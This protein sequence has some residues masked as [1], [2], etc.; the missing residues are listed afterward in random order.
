[1]NDF[2]MGGN[3]GMRQ[4]ASPTP[5]PGLMPAEL[6]NGSQSEQNGFG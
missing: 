4:T 2:A 5:S 1:M 3:G 6:Q